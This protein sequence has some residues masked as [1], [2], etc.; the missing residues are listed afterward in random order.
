MKNE[1]AVWEALQEESSGLKI[2]T[3]CSL[4]LNWFRSLEQFLLQV[5]AEIRA[6]F[7]AISQ[8]FLHALSGWRLGWFGIGPAGIGR[9]SW[10]NRSLLNG[11]IFLPKQ[12]GPV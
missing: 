3:L 2:F 11:R 8:G 12:T 1:S 10:Q 4:R 7:E 6:L 9:E 5:R